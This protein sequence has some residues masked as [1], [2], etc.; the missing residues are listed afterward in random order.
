[1]IIDGGPVGIPNHVI[2]IRREM[3]VDTLL[4]HHVTSN[5]VTS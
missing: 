4:H 1:M 2:E 5:S 3:R